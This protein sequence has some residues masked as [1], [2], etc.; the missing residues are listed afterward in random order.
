MPTTLLI[1]EFITW[2]ILYFCFLFII[3]MQFL[4]EEEQ[5]ITKSFFLSWFSR[6]LECL[7]NKFLKKLRRHNEMAENFRAKAK[8]E[9]GWSLCKKSAREE[10][11]PCPFINYFKIKKWKILQC[12][13]FL[14][15][16]KSFKSRF[17]WLFVFKFFYND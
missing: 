10:L 16:I 12:S 9:I 6:N 14:N 1:I 4:E 8:S 15:Q 5:R 2:R 3:F 7:L 13:I 17:Y 11:K